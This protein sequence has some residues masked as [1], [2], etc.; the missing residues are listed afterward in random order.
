MARDASTLHTPPQ[1]WVHISH[2]CFSNSVCACTLCSPP[3]QHMHTHPHPLTRK[4]AHTHLK[5]S[6][7]AAGAPT[8]HRCT[9]PTHA[10]LA[11]L[12]RPAPPGAGRT[13][14]YRRDEAR[15]DGDRRP[16]PFKSRGGSGAGPT[17]RP[18]G[19]AVPLINMKAAA[20]A[21]N[22]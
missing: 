1:P 5:C 11:S 20:A 9:Y 22:G 12:P 21:A 14:R 2:A 4:G 6:S 19:R 3:W 16:P 15:Q 10:S 8:P 13:P 18:R 17:R 7:A